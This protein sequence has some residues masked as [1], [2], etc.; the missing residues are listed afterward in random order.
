[1]SLVSLLLPVKDIRTDSMPWTAVWPKQTLILG[2]TYNQP[3]W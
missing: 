1:M 3:H 2:T